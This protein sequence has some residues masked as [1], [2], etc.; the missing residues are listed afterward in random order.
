MYEANSLLYVTSF[1]LWHLSVQYVYTDLPQMML[2]DHCIFVF[3]NVPLCKQFGGIWQ[4]I[5]EWFDC[6]LHVFFIFL[7]LLLLCLATRYVRLHMSTLVVVGGYLPIGVKFAWLVDLGIV[8][9]FPIA[10]L[11]F[12]LVIYL[13]R[14]ILLVSWIKATCWMC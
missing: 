10:S 2:W 3:F 8:F 9:W 12:Q 6:M 11:H 4:Y 7:V 13:F 1:N 5:V 14:N